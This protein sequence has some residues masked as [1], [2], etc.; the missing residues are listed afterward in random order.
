MIDKTLKKSEGKIC[1]KVIRFGC[2]FYVLWLTGGEG[3]QNLVYATAR[4]I[5][6]WHQ[7]S[8]SAQRRRIEQ[9][10][11]EEEWPLLLAWEALLFEMYQMTPL[12][13]VLSCRYL[14]FYPNEFIQRV[15][16]NEQPLFLLT[17]AMREKLIEYS[18]IR[19]PQHIIAEWLRL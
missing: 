12:A 9:E 17:R 16:L 10:S 14:S 18:K 8:Y 4:T 19:T 2:S 11:I 15:A 7:K 5:S 13:T 1:Y 6:G 3:T